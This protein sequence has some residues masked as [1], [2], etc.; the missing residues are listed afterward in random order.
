MNV[1]LAKAS[2]LFQIQTQIGCGQPG[3]PPTDTEND[4]SPRELIPLADQA[5]Y[6]AKSLGRN[7]GEGA[8]A[9]EEQMTEPVSSDLPY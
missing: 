2:K 5:L 9:V 7:C 1:G 3:I 8:E 4:L 6:W